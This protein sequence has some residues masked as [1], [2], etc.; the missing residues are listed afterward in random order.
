MGPGVKK[1]NIPSM[2]T[3]LVPVA[4]NAGYNGLTHNV[5]ESDSYFNFVN[6]YYL[7]EI[8]KCGYKFFKRDCAGNKLYPLDYNI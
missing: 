6:A 7:E 4:Y 2:K 1:T 3:P 5:T 8:P